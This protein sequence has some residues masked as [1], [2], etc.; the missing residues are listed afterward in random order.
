MVPI[1]DPVVFRD[2]ARPIKSIMSD[3][4]LMKSAND[5]EIHLYSLNRMNFLGLIFHTNWNRREITIQEID[6]AG[7]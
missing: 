5:P 3:V 2:G 6:G 7:I 4:Y 1:T